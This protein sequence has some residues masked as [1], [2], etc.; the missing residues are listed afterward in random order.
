MSA[1]RVGGEYKNEE[2]VEL[3]DRSRT[4][5]A[6]EKSQHSVFHASRN[7]KI[8]KVHSQGWKIR[9]VR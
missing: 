6:A 5:Y 7:L 8:N 9:G 3:G 4:F 1:G 2:V